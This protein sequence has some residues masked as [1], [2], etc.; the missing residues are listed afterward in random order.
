MV[1]ILFLGNSEKQD[2]YF[3]KSVKEEKRERLREFAGG[4][5]GTQ[6]GAV[7]LWNLDFWKKFCQHA[8]HLEMCKH[9]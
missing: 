5:Q 6:S 3:F 4:R 8:K 9:K 7:S 2:Q 1:L